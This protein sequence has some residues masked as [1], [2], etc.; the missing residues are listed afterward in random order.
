MR[1]SKYKTHLLAFLVIQSFLTVACDKRTAPKNQAAATASPGAGTPI[2]TA[3][4]TTVVST[5]TGSTTSTGTTTTTTTVTETP[6]TTST[7]TTTTTNSGSIVLASG[8]TFNIPASPA[9][10]RCGSV[11]GHLIDQANCSVN[12]LTGSSQNLGM[13]MQMVR[14]GGSG[15][16]P[17]V[18][19]CTGENLNMSG[20]TCQTL[21]TGKTFQP[22][23][24]GCGSRIKTFNAGTADEAICVVNY[25]GP[26]QAFNKTMGMVLMS[27]KKSVCDQAQCTCTNNENYNYSNAGW[28]CGLP[29]PVAQ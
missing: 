13:V 22:E 16:C 20:W 9:V 8:L 24:R 19:M 12:H 28:S 27:G 14:A 23:I 6:V 21:P 26:M 7:T 15:A 17:S 10:L 5:A 4:D 3:V 1:P 2:P 18:C 29:V 11:I 25:R